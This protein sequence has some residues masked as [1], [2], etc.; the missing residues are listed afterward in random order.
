MDRITLDHLKGACQKERELFEN[1]FPNGA[2]VNKANALKAVKAGLNVEWLAELLPQRAQ[3]MYDKS[4]QSIW[5]K[6][7]KDTDRAW[8]KLSVKLGTHG[9][10]VEEADWKANN[11]AVERAE[12]RYDKD[13]ALRLIP[14]LKAL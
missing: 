13:A 2:V 1:V 8:K 5:E 11:R 7:D 4:M 3:K 9:I 10:Q 12:R 14:F 6:Y